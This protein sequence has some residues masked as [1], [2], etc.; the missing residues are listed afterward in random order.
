VSAEPVLKITPMLRLD[1]F[2]LA[3]N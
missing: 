3:W 1:R 2:L